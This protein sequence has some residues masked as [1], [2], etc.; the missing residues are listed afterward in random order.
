MGIQIL[1]EGDQV[2]ILFGPCQGA[3]GTIRRMRL[4]RY[5]EVWAD[6]QIPK[7]IRERLCPGVCTLR[8]YH[9][10]KMSQLRL[11]RVGRKR[12]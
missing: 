11:L 10:I 5:G 3:R 4:G 8:G 2:Q 7:K 12:G 6:V 1:D 9:L